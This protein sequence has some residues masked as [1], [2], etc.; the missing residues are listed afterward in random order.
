MSVI[1]P[2]HMADIVDNMAYFEETSPGANPTGAPTLIAVPLVNTINKTE[3]WRNDVR[4]VLGKVDRHTVLKL[5]KE[6]NF[7]LSYDIYDTDF[8][9][10]GTEL[11]G[12]AGTIEKTLCFILPVD[13]NGQTYYKRFRG[14]IT[15]T[16]NISIED[17]YSVDHSWIAKT[18]SPYLTL[19]ELKLDLGLSTTATLTWPTTPTDIPWT[20]LK[21]SATTDKPLTIN[22]VA[23]YCMSLNISIERGPTPAEAVANETFFYIKAGYRKVT[24]S[25]TLYLTGKEIDTLF[26]AFTSFLLT[27]KLSDSPACDISMASTLI[28]SESDGITAGENSYIMLECNID[29][30]SFT[31]TSV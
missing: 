3:S 30:A 5:K 26:R 13:L 1:I 19:D 17:T 31:V 27:Y 9:Q 12:G 6:N 24:G 23:T 7:N 8:L 22:G 11:S 29:S 25:M 4:F 21:P 20:N 2:T 14:C 15:D 18:V 16:V 10:Y 28:T